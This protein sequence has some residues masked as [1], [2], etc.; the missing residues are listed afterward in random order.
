MRDRGRQRVAACSCF[1]CMTGAL[2][3]L[4]TTKGGGATRGQCDHSI[5]F[6]AISVSPGGDAEVWLMKGVKALLLRAAVEKIPPSTKL[7]VRHFGGAGHSSAWWT[8]GH[9]LWLRGL[10]R[11]LWRSGGEH[12]GKGFPATCEARFERIHVFLKLKLVPFC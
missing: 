12:G 11:A 4:S 5:T 9:L 3:E 8:S 2:I 10:V 7:V 6:I 1:G